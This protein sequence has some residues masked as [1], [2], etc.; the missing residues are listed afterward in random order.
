MLKTGIGATRSSIARPENSVGSNWMMGVASNDPFSQNQDP[1][2]FGVV[3]HYPKVAFGAVGLTRECLKRNMP[4]NL[5][6][7]LLGRRVLPIH[8]AYEGQLSPAL[9]FPPPITFSVNFIDRLDH[10]GAGLSRSRV[11]LRKSGKGGLPS[12]GGGGATAQDPRPSAVFQACLYVGCTWPPSHAA[13]FSSLTP[14]DLAR[15]EGFRRARFR[16]QARVSGLM[17]T[18]MEDMMSTPAQI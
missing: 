3:G 6:G 10:V 18:L 15:P 13:T 11:P 16:A 2:P 1:D 14:Q 8:A 5:L 7:N 4:P 17:G 12:P 9:I